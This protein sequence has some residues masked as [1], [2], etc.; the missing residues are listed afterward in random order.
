MILAPKA[1][2]EEFKIQTLQKPRIRFLG[3]AQTVTGSK[4]LITY[5][6]K[7]IL[8]DCGLFQGLKELRLKNWDRFPIDPQKID[9]ILLTHAHIDHSGYIPR[10]VKEGFRG[11]IFCSSATAELCQVMLLDSAHL[12]EEEASWLN[13]RKLSKHSPALPLYTI[14]DA[15][16]ALR[17]FQPQSFQSFFDILPGWRARFL[18]AGHILGAAQILLEVGGVRIA[19]S[20]DIGRPEDPLLLP[21]DRLPDVDCLVVEATYGDRKHE[22]SDPKTELCAIINEAVKKKGVILIP[23]FTVGR[24]QML[25]H[26]LSELRKDKKIPEIPM[27]LNSPMATSATSIFC[28][29]PDL[30]KLTTQQCNR[31]SEDFE[32][33]KSVEESKFLN[34]QKGPMIIIAGSGMATGGRILHHLEAFAENPNNVIVLSGFQAMGTRGRQLQDGAPEVKIHG[35]MVPVKASVKMIENLSAHAD[36]T[37]IIDWLKKSEFKAKKV[38]VTHG[39]PASVTAMKLQ[40][41]KEFQTECIAPHQDQEYVLS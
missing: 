17:Y 12:Q 32:Y 2:L 15:E 14:E 5:G 23:A 36:F 39:E 41:E 1:A 10:L 30:H 13:K 21:P 7:Q 25:M 6:E 27:Y 26:F 9:A 19:F 22:A 16:A 37:E 11:K 34:E 28:R 40:I 20:G 4:Y 31:M 29:H 35:R 38:F 8:V 18:S 33:I 3:G 24:T